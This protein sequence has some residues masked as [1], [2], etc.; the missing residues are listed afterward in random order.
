MCGKE[1]ATTLKSISEKFF[2]L[3]KKKEKKE[4][5]KTL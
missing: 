3:T 4:R 5:K 2:K 1:A